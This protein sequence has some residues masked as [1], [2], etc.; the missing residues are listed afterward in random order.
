MSSPIVRVRLDGTFY[1]GVIIL[2][3][4]RWDGRSRHVACQIPAD[5]LLTPRLKYETKA[6]QCH[7]YR[8][9]ILSKRC[10]LMTWQRRMPAYEG[11][12]VSFA[13]H[14]ASYRASSLQMVHDSQV[15][16]FVNSPG[17]GVGR[18]MGPRTRYIELSPPP[19]IPLPNKPTMPVDRL[20][21]DLAR[22]PLP[23]LL[24]QDILPGFEKMHRESLVDFVNQAGFGYVRDR[25]HVAGFEPHAFRQAAQVPP[26]KDFNEQWT[27]A[28]LELISLLKHDQPMAYVSEHLPNMEELRTAPVRPLDEFER[29]SLK[30][31][32]DDH[33]HITAQ[34]TTNRIQM[35][36]AVRDRPLFGL[37]P[38][39]PG[40]LLKAF[41]YELQRHPLRP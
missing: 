20:E 3:G 30:L 36:K 5:F 6:V 8:K 19:Q 10:R 13:D 1:R 21:Q 4:P 12:G 16:Q 27:I 25:E 29:R 15:N 22:Q 11:D 28:R 40:T 18:G 31:L 23:R 32:A 17:F 7:H 37:P 35:L 24:P 34:S 33:R 38:V 14:M 41:S 9:P 2:V 39:E 26:A